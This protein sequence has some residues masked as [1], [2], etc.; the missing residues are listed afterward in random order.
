[1]ALV[2]LIA[3][4]N[5]ANLLLVRATARKQE[6]AIRC[7]L[8]AT[9]SRIVRQLLTESVLLSMAG[10]VLGIAL[11]LAGVRALLAISPASL[12]RIGEDGSSLGVD[13]RVLLFTLAVSLLTG[14]LFG[15]LP[16]FT[17]SRTDL[18]TAL[19]ENNGRSGSGFRQSKT[20]SMLVI[21]EVSL[22]LVLLIGSLLLI[23]AFMALHLVRPGFDGHDVLTLEMSLTGNRFQTT[24]GVA[25]L[26]KNGRDRLHATPG[27]KLSAAAYW[28]PI[29]VDDGLPF[30]IAGQPVDKDH[31]YGSRWMSISPG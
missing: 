29:Q 3:C 15:L 6:F 30:E 25:Q 21:S 9:R 26:S 18:N 16:A 27:V 7:A 13:W 20:R 4:A 23:R 2:F 28:L 1:V 24:A 17:A 11:G 10:G 22:A 31:Q 5:V 12:P 19:K 8:G 14:I